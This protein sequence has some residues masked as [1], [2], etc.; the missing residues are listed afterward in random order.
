[1]VLIMIL[2]IRIFISA[3]PLVMWIALDGV[4]SLLNYHG[5]DKFPFFGSVVGSKLPCLFHIYLVFNH[6]VRLSS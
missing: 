6:T 1:M 2:S 5:G 4:F 3:R